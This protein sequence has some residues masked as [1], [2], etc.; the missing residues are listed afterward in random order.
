MSEEL[1]PCPFCGG[2]DVIAFW[3][4][5]KT[6]YVT[7]DGCG[8]MTSDWETEKEARERWNRRAEGQGIP[9]PRDKYGERINIGDY[10]YDGVVC[11]QAFSFTLVED[12]QEWFVSYEADGKHH[13]NLCSNVTACPLGADGKPILVG[14]TV[15]QMEGFGRPVRIKGY[16][17]SESTEVVGVVVDGAGLQN[18][19]T[20]THEPPDSWEELEED[21]AMQSL[22]YCDKRGL[23]VVSEPSFRRMAHDVVARAKKLAGI[24]GG[25]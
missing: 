25:E 9:Y 21:L 5:D 12:D 23:T 14:E 7:C 19:A 24:E 16:R 18:A 4:H 13:L 2:E 10:V 8:N 6:R 1:K 3:T 17:R 15:Y 20:F 22:D 11:A